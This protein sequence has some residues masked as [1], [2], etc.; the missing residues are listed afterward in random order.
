LA[1]GTVKSPI[2]NALNTS[3]INALF[4][5][6]ILQ[7]GLVRVILA[8]R[9]N[10][11]AAFHQRSVQTLETAL[12]TAPAYQAWTA[13]DPGAEKPID[14][15]YDA[16]PELSKEMIRGHFPGGLVPNHRD[17][18]EG[19][20]SGE[21]EYTFTSGTTGERVVN[22]W[23]QDWWDAAEASSWKLNS[24]LARLPYP[25]KEAKLASSLNVGICCEEDL[26]MEYR[27]TGRKLYLNEKI[28]LIQWQGRHYERMARELKYFEP[29]I[30]EANPSLL[31]RL[32][33]WAIDEGVE[34]YSPA[35]IVFTYEF[36]SEI[37]LAAIRTVFSSPLVSSF[38]TTETGFVLE[39]CE[40]GFLHQ[41]IDFCRIDFYPLK[42]KYG[43][44]DLGRM[45]VTTFGNP[46]NTVVRFDT[47]DLVR[48]YPSGECKCGRKEGLIARAVEGR[49][50]NA[51]FTTGG[52]LITTMA[53]DNTLG[54]IAGIRD[55]HLEQ[56]SR[57]QY[58]LE[59]M[60]K[61]DAGVI[62]DEA[63]HALELLYGR[64]GEY[65]IKITPNILSGPAGKF[66]R[67][68]ANFEF[69]MKE[70]FI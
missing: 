51:T 23:N 58:E 33:Y 61:G 5:C 11:P 40:K 14:Q 38:G 60:V 30:L 53:L 67:T 13:L 12:N 66:R 27:T 20:R 8:E 37:H 70:M 32:A 21:I 26:P 35:V 43:G 47:G 54:M 25:Q 22:I 69:D 18:E 19:L 3:F 16:M 2:K 15:R 24:A 39:E 4:F 55:Y 41:N 48:L 29:V 50:S 44:P 56:N 64:D 45:L 31:A 59:L 42:E 36:I 57:T 10:Y 46:W 49:L 9:Y 17:I 1:R 28:S 7:K 68:Q 6:I 34:L 65:T 63:R 52:E 62:C